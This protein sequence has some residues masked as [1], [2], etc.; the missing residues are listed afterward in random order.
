M[1]RLYLISIK[2]PFYVI[3]YV[4]SQTLG[5]KGQERTRIRCYK[6]FSLSRT[7]DKKEF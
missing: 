2:F 1:F 7:I 6:F 3:Y 5:F 4:F